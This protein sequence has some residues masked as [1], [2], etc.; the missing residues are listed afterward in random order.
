[1]YKGQTSSI[2]SIMMSHMNFC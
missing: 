2:S 1:M